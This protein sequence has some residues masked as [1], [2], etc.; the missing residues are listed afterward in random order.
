MAILQHQ[1]ARQV[2]IA[3]AGGVIE[4]EAPRHNPDDGVG[5]VIDFQWLPDDAEIAA[6]VALPE[7]VVENNDGV[8]AI[9]G[10]GWLDI[11]TEKRAHIKENSR[12]SL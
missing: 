6:E 9:L 3:G 4:R 1:A 5:R 12:H 8:A 2:D 10:I 7:A 11:A